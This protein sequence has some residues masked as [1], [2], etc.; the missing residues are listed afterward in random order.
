MKGTRFGWAYDFLEMLVDDQM[1]FLLLLPI[2]VCLC[3]TLNAKN[4]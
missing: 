1:C 3:A 2:P 4:I